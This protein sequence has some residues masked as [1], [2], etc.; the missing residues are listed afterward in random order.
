MVLKTREKLIEVARQLFVR[1]GVAKTT[2]NDIANASEKGRRTIYTYFKNK[3]EIYEAVLDSESDSLVANLRAEASRPGP[4]TERLAGYLR[5]RLEHNNLQAASPLRVWLKFDTRRL[6]RVNRM[7]LD[8]EKAIFENLLEEG[9]EA[10]VFD[11]ARC[12]LLAVF[13]DELLTRLELP[14][15][16]NP[17]RR[18]LLFDSFIEFIL[19]DISIK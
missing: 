7:V 16:V 14:E 15:N 8:K 6:E 19:T 2:M 17:A 10:G 12:R 18:K 5:F 4:V 9:C 13:L 11:R 1:K 3:K